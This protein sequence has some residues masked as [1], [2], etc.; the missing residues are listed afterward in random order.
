MAARPFAVRSITSP[1]L[2]PDSSQDSSKEV[3]LALFAEVAMEPTLFSINWAE[4]SASLK[5]SEYI[6]SLNALLAARVFAN[7]RVDPLLF[8][9]RAVNSSRNCLPGAALNMA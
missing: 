2:R 7:D 5:E 9:T 4:N 6:A 8:S 1:R 3:A